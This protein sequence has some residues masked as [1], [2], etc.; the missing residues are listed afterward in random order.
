S[1]ERQ[2]TDIN[3]LVAE[4]AL[5]AYHGLRGQAGP[6]FQVSMETDL[7]RSLAP[8]PVFAQELSRVV[9]NLT[10]NAC[11]AAHEKKVAGPGFMPRVRL[12]TRDV[13]EEVELRFWDNGTGIAPG[14]RDKIFLPFFT[15][16]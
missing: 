13:G 11:Y 12:V 1:G 14:L 9:V 6:A 8:L 4:H 15:T 10:L 3:A 16:K 7:D 5:L 2:L